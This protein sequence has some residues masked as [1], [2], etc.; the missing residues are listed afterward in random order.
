MHN[1]IP[2]FMN[3]VIFSPITAFLLAFT[4][5]T[6]FIFHFRDMGVWETQRKDALLRKTVPLQE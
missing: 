5:L 4:L 2:L 6:T 1:N 3:Y